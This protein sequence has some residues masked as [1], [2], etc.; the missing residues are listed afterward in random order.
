MPVFAHPALLWGLL[1]VSLPVLVHLLLRPRPRAVLFPAL[2]LLRAT[3]ETGQRANRVQNILLLLLRAT[4]IG[5]IVLL[6]AGPRPGNSAVSRAGTAPQ[7]CVLVVDDSLSAS[8]RLRYDTS[9]TILDDIRATAIDFI[10][11]SYAWPLG[12]GLAVLFASGENSTAALTADRDMLLKRIR[13]HS[14]GEQHAHPLGETLQEATALL[15]DATAG[16]KRIV[17]LTDAT[18]AAWRNVQPGLIDRDLTIVVRGVGPPADQRTNLSIRTIIASDTVQPRASEMPLRVAL[19]ATG[20]NTDCVLTAQADGTTVMQRAGLSLTADRIHDVTLDIPAGE[21]G[22]HALQFTL[23]PADTLAADQHH[24]VT[25]QTGLRPLVWLLVPKNVD[26]QRDITTLVLH[27]LL[28]PTGLPDERQRVDVRI[29]RSA[30]LRALHDDLM[31][32]SPKRTPAMFILPSA[33]ELNAAGLN[34]IEQAVR[35]GATALLIP[36]P[37]DPAP[38]WPGLRSHLTTHGVEHEPLPA[39]VTIQGHPVERGADE[40]ILAVPLAGAQVLRRV[41]AGPLQSDVDVL[42]SYTDGVPATVARGVG[43][44]RIVLMTTSPDPAWS[45]LGVRAAGLLAWL[46]AQVDRALGP[47]D[48]AAML[49]AHELSTRSF[50]ALPHAGLVR[51]VM[52]GES[53]PA[54]RRLAAGVP[55][56]PWPTDK[57]G[58]YSIY[59]DDDEQPRVH[60]AVNWPTE[61]F[62]LTPIT[63]DELS[64]LFGQ[65]NVTV[66]LPQP[67]ADAATPR[68]W[69]TILGLAHLPGILAAALLALFIVELWLATRHNRSARPSQS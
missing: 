60:Y 65:E 48:A 20:I 2:N 32:A 11:D 34:A 23:Q 30:D 5:L 50:G 45:D 69:T 31:S 25:W 26:P 61:E 58:I 53:E 27:N 39:S 46:H 1:A 15:H 41:R 59:A 21:P 56:T 55:H 35:R 40:D 7:H 22:P 28:A 37:E 12:S 24:Y 13:E 52:P 18:A 36:T 63:A 8:Y 68:T 6:L 16:R 42:A 14:P 43:S 66:H 19:S 64:R 4:L 3:L 9:D 38:D 67:A 57:A 10:R 47:P 49:T 44:G 51:I 54:W 33:T 29:A 17:V 62:D